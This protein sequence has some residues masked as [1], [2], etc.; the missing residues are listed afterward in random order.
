MRRYLQLILLLTMTTT[1]ALSQSDF[2]TQQ[3]KFERVK[4]AYDQKWDNLKNELSKKGVDGPFKLFMTAYKSEGKLEVWLQTESQKQ[5]KHF[6]TYNFCEHSGTLGPKTKEGDRQ[7]PEGFYHISAFNP[8]SNF[9]LSLGINYPNSV[10]RLRSGEDK[11]GSDIYIHGSCVT[12]GCIPL[13]DEK[14]KEVYV[15]AVEARNSGQTNIPVYI[16]PFKMT[17]RNFKKH[18]AQYPIQTKFWQSLQ[19]GYAYFEKNRTLPK[20]IQVKGNYLT[21]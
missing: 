18:T 7:T 21:K 16:F 15:L 2:K 5:Y 14:I 11:P 13:T 10:D 6:K 19:P 3:L 20:V 12:I 8:K 9:Y 4:T 17:E 1:S